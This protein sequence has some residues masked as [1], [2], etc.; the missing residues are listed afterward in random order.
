MLS[1]RDP[2]WNLEIMGFGSGNIGAYG[3]YLTSLC[4]GLNLAGYSFTPSTL[5]RE[6]K[7]RN[8]WTGEFKNYIDVGNIVSKWGDIFTSF[9]SMEP[10]TDLHFGFETITVCKVSAKGIGGTG[11]HFV[12]LKSVDADPLIGDPWTGTDDRLSKRYGTLGGILGIRVFHIKSPVKET[13]DIRLQILDDNKILTEGDVREAVERYNLLPK[14]EIDLT[15]ANARIKDL[16]G[17]VGTLKGDLM[18]EAES[19]RIENNKL[20]EELANY[21]SSVATA[22]DCTQDLPRILKAVNDLVVEA[23]K[24]PDAQKQIKALAEQVSELT[25]KWKELDAAQVRLG[26]D[27]DSLKREREELYKA[28]RSVGYVVEDNESVVNLI[29]TLRTNHSVA[30]ELPLLNLLVERFKSIWQKK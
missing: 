23:D 12:L 25:L 20:R 4:E 18:R 1:Q 2:K 28:I 30:V 10:Y 24:L 11:T 8:L 29:R 16:E 13:M 14:R 3:C 15:N 9:K 27:Y 7:D 21:K 19:N 17:I 26:R 6:L 22:L 5:N